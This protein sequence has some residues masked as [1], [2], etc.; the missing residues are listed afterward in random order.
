MLQKI[1]MNNFRRNNVALALITWSIAMSFLYIPESRS[2]LSIGP[3]GYITVK[4]GGSLM[5][6]T[7]LHIKSVAD[8]S[9]ALADQNVNGNIT[10]TGDVSV[11]RYMAADVWHN[12]ASPVSNETSNCFTGTDLVFWYNET[13]IWNDWNFGWTW[14][15]GATGGPLMVF[16]GYDVYFDTS[17]VTVNY[18]A[19]GTETLNT[20][21]FTYN[22]TISDPTPNP[23]EIPSHMGWNLSGN[24]YPS[25]VDWLAASGWDKSDINDAKYIWDGTN[26]VYTIFIGGGS[27]YGLNGGT[28]FIPSNQGFWVQAIQNGTFGINNAVRL[29]SMT[30]TP[31]FYKLDPVDYP[32]ID[33]VAKG[34]GKQDEVAL[35]FI[36]GTTS[37]FDVDFDAT[38]LYSFIESVPQISIQSGDQIFALNTYPELHD[39]MG[40]RLNFLCGVSGSYSIS[41][42]ER[43][44]LDKRVIVYLKDDLTNKMINLSTDSCYIFHHNVLNQKERF[45]IWLNPSED[46][47]NNIKNESSFSV[48]A[49]GN[50]ISVL[51]NTF[52]DFTGTIYVSNMLGQCVYLT[53]VNNEA[54]VEF[55]LNVPTGYYIISVV[56]ESNMLNYKILLY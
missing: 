13:Q 25:P 31:D 29:G 52:E 53:D 35:R 5:I 44:N 12:V 55:Q 46:I 54:K 24:P 3:G 26:D 30:A 45:T 43:S 15:S 56:S 18:E 33:L 9:G 40:V 4:S 22:V 39:N 37:G 28:R 10:I 34:N 8:S 47:I 19:T 41:L 50:K 23:A 38:K 1:Q 16:R 42:S 6:D 2:Q 11:E 20:G 36:Q 49:N 48:F 27:P 32:V 21:P 51:K 14:Y 7:D 17:P